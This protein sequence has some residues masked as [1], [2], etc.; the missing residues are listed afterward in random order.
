MLE[1]LWNHLEKL[2]WNSLED[3][4]LLWAESGDL[5]NLQEKN[6]LM[7]WK[8]TGLKLLDCM[9]DLKSI[10]DHWIDLKYSSD[11]PIHIIINLCLLSF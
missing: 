9:L 1:L 3:R 10:G 4:K 7:N 11:K 8:I 2:L 6:S 5:H